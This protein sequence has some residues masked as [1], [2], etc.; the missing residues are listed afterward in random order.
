[1]SIINIKN[2]YLRRFIV[3]VL[4]PIFVPIGALFVAVFEFFHAMGEI[5]E[6][7]INAWKGK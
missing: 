7:F 5:G 1:M 4:F 3:L 6:S 2:N